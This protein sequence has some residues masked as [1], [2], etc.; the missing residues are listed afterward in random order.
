MET[1]GRPRQ[2]NRPFQS[3]GI[4]YRRSEGCAIFV[5]R[6]FAADPVFEELRFS[7]R[8]GHVALAATFRGVTVVTTHLRWEPDGTP[9]AT[10][11]GR[12]QLAEVLDRWPAGARIV[13]GDFNADAGSVVLALARERGLGDAYAAM[14]DAYTCNANGTRKRIDFILHSADL[15]ATPTP[16]RLKVTD[17]TPLPGVGEPSDHLAI[18]A[19]V[20]KEERPSET[21]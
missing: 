7:D 21:R 16:L 6:A 17:D 5:R 18:E 8:S 13:C 10:H 19:R 3:V 15:G 11:R 14:P 2:G 1:G 12:A 4:E 20:Y 9:A